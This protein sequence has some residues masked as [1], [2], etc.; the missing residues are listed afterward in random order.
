MLARFTCK[1]RNTFYTYVTHGKRRLIMKDTASTQIISTSNNCQ[2]NIQALFAHTDV[3][4]VQGYDKFRKVIYWNLASEKL[5][6]Y[7]EKQ[8][9]GQTI[10]SLF[11]AKSEHEEIIDCYD[12]FL[13][14]DNAVPSTETM[15]LHANGMP[16]QIF[17]SFVK[18]QNQDDEREMYRIDID[19]S[20]QR[21]MESLIHH[22]EELLNSIFHA[23]PDLFFLMDP[24]GTIRDYHAN[25][26]NELYL[27]PKKFLGKRMFDVLPQHAAMLF[28]ENI[29]VVLDT[30]EMTTFEYQLTMPHGIKQ[31][32]TR[33]V[34][35]PDSKQVVA[36]V[37][38]ITEQKF[39]EDAVRNRDNVY[40]Q[41]FEKNKAI[42]LIIDPVDGHILE[43]N[44]AAT[45]FYGYSL[46]KL[47]SMRINDINTLS[48]NDVFNEMQRAEIE[49]RLF[50]N[51]RHK[52]ASGEIKDVEVYSG[53]IDIN[54]KVL[55]YC[56]IQDVSK[57][58]QAESALAATEQQ[59]RDLLNNATSVIYMKDLSGRYM[60]VNQLYEKVFNVKE[61]E[62]KN[63]TDYDLFSKEVADKLTK[64]DSKVIEQG[65][66]LEIEEIVPHA[67]GNH[68]YL[69]VKYPLRNSK[70]EI[71]AI[72]GISTDI[73]ERK[74]VEKQMRYQSHFDLLTTLPN[75]ILALD[76]LTQML[77][78]AKRSHEK[79]AV[80]FLDIDDFKKINDSLGHEV[81]DSLLVEAG[82]RLSQVVS[83]ED[84][85]GRL[86]GDEF[87]VL[88]RGLSN[89]TEAS[90]VIE[91]I[92]NR[93]REAFVI[94][95]RQLIL[96][97]SIGISVYPDDGTTSSELL[98]N[99]DTAMYQA[100]EKGR[101]TYSYFTAAM[102]RD[103]SRRLAI[104][105]QLRGALDRNEFEVHY[106][107]QFGIPDTEVIGAEALLRWINPLL[108][109][110]S[111][112]EFIPV[113]EQTGI[114]VALGE[115]VLIQALRF[116]NIWQVYHHHELRMAVNISPRQFRDHNLVDFIRDNLKQSLIPAHLLELEI[117][118][119]VLMTGHTYIGD[120]IEQLHLL[121]IKLSMDDFGT[122]YSSLNYLRQYPFNILKIDRC[123]VEG[124][125]KGNKDKEL[126]IATIAMAHALGLKVVAEGVETEDQLE[127]LTELKCDIVQCY[128]LAR[129]MQAS[130]LIEM[131]EHH[132][133]NEKLM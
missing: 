60:A 4:A 40:R 1:P 129:P 29:S 131:S 31:Y 48:E 47:T 22:D 52:L 33:L 97:A 95:E 123:F 122:G 87:I 109:R 71:Y 66:T 77:I 116:L 125:N 104:E 112:A 57:R 121:G 18:L 55:S 64:I 91:G 90:T 63:K 132:L 65:I 118:E 68:V 23:L 120:A 67:D 39:A 6:G 94:D 85:V 73:T 2:K 119:G 34:G 32:E 93:F 58:K 117:T 43:A 44:H 26:S 13:N 62:V 99:A 49:E 14:N 114:I 86:G 61:S 41:M 74:E 36:I 89:G 82:A 101:N 126:V 100:K 92:L 115:F 128:L 51:F 15:L 28:T 8:A 130:A 88:L 98:R 45:E 105:E 111:P 16:L 20:K 27:S 30:G 50:F 96:T 113:A 25:E 84:T 3:I 17:S 72:C 75:R 9:L 11:V 127:A 46:N 21:K 124:L 102:N 5:Y 38:D 37:R 35:L 81:G 79:V 12:D 53:P 10:E 106:Q 83:N 133:I 59:L 108:G 103:I 78:E 80:L 7:T 42:K 24:D 70:G 54:G 56:I 107:P 19:V 76:R 69:S 110:V